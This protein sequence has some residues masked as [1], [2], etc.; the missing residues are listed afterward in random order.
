MN[1]E[2][3]T[4]PRAVGTRC[5]RRQ[6]VFVAEPEAAV[7]EDDGAEFRQ[8]DVGFARERLV[9]RAVDGE[10]VAETVENGAQCELGLGIAPAD[11]G[12]ELRAF[13]RCE[14]VHGKRTQMPAAEKINTD[15]VR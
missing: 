11:A 15:S 7:D 12:H 1:R 3:A 14:D 13:F 5:K 2:T 10:A 6:G 4:V 8:D 9:F